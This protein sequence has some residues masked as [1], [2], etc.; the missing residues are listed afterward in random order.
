MS[1]WVPRSLFGQML[2]ILLAGLL[3]S[4][5]L[6]TLIFVAD[7]ARAVRAIGAYAA[8]QRI[9]NL[10]QLINAAP[11]DWRA[12]IAAG[13][14][15]AT[16]RVAL[17]PRPPDFA[18]AGDGSD[19]AT[20]RRYLAAQLPPTLANK[21][22]VAVSAARPGLGGFPPPPGFFRGFAPGMP[23][24][25]PMSMTGMM[26]MGTPPPFSPPW[27][28]GAGALRSL[29][30]AMQLSD[31]QWL[32][33]ATALPD[34][35]P[36]TPW[37]FV[38]AMASMAVIV[39]VAT[40]WA[41]RR[42]TTPLRVLVQAAEQ[43]G[44]N[45]NAPPLLEVGSTEMRQAAHSFNQM[46]AGIRRLL[47]NRMRMLAALSH[48]LRTPLTLLRLRTESLAET[49]DR[50]RMLATINEL[51]AMVGASLAF[52]R[53]QARAEAWRRTDVGALLASIVDDMADAG[54]PVT[55]GAGRAG[56]PVVPA[57]CVAAGSDQPDR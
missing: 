13:A 28:L 50:D 5:V 34:A 12:R 44:R 27:M 53:D 51:D 40:V 48:D 9:A 18:A 23:M 45:V 36:A 1:R 17:S 2:L 29:Q 4:Y 15:D 20:V 3:V 56:G 52:A 21:L 25:G 26:P 14:S 47:D 22:A 24:D 16:L 33:F 42:V 38:A 46:Q 57:R 41:V 35:A 39:V 7:R 30:A 6:G 31:R 49:D 10:A 19:S 54:L 55:L 37:S 8:T 11:A 43:L 32:V